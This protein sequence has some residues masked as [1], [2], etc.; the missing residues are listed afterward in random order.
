VDCGDEV[1]D[2]LAEVLD[3]PGCRLVRKPTVPAEGENYKYSLFER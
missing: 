2:W 3:K 1:A